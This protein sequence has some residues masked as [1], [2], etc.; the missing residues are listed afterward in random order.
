M[1]SQEFRLH[2]ETPDG[3]YTAQFVQKWV[4]YYT[5][6]TSAES[7]DHLGRNMTEREKALLTQDQKENMEELKKLVNEY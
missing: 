2:M 1:L 7:I 6:I 4:E 3:D 5:E